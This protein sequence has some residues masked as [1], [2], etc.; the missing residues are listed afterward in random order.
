MEK[1]SIP[2]DRKNAQI[3]PILK[4]GIKSNPADNRPIS[5]TSA[6]GKIMECIIMD[7]IVAYMNDYNFLLW[8]PSIADDDDFLFNVEGEFCCGCGGQ[9]VRSIDEQNQELD[10]SLEHADVCV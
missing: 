6:V 9:C 1:G 5:I 4:K 7:F 2:C 3:T 8:S 10:R